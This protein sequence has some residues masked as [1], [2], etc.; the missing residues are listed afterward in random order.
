MFCFICIVCVQ[1]II[2]ATAPP[3]IVPPIPAT[4]PPPGPQIFSSLA[5]LFAPGSTTAV[6][7]SSSSDAAILGARP[8]PAWVGAAVDRLNLVARARGGVG[9][10]C[11][12]SGSGKSTLLQALGT[13]TPLPWDSTRALVSNFPP[14]LGPEKVEHLLSSVGLNTVPSYL[15]PFHV[16]STGEKYRSLLA[17]QIAQRL[18]DRAAMARDGVEEPLIVI[19]EFTSVL[20][21]AAAKSTS[22][23]FARAL[24]THRI[25]NCVLASCHWDI[26]PFLQPD[27]VVV[28][29]SPNRWQS[30]LRCP[31]ATDV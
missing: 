19:D 25:T 24:R 4:P 2:P 12:P 10:I 23:A 16:L 28:C 6:S 1:L 15:K 5:G 17:R 26:V 13:E 30:V 9:L 3:P 21:R 18:A 8:S 14:S 31:R 11:G 29:V 27:W 20:D 22:V 7:L